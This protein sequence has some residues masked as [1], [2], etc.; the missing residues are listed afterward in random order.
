MRMS[1]AVRIAI[2]VKPG[3]ARTRVGGSHGDALVVAVTARAVDGKATAAAL[4]AVA[5]AFGVGRRSVT[6][7]S[8]ATSRTKIVT[9]DPAPAGLYDRLSDLKIIGEPR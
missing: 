7:A 3:A 6:L 2:R 1:E 5:E 9:I 4:T 8:G